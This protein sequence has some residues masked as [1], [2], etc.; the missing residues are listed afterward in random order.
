[1]LGAL[2][3]WYS[4]LEPTPKKIA[5]QPNIAEIDS[6][7][8]KATFKNS[9][10]EISMLTQQSKISENTS[11]STDQ[12]STVTF[13][14][15][16]GAKF[17]MA[18]LTK[19][20]FETLNG[21]DSANLSITI[22]EGQIQLLSSDPNKR[23]FEVTKKGKALSL[24]ELQT[25][26]EK[27][28]PSLPETSQI[29]AVAEPTPPEKKPVVKTLEQKKLAHTENSLDQ[30]DIN[31]VMRNQTSFLHRCYINYMLRSQRLD[32]SG[33]VVLSFVIQPTGKVINT[34]IISSPIQ[35]DQLDRCL[36]D[37]ISRASF[38]EFSSQAIL[39]QAYPIH[40]D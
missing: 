1:M 13:H 30:E 4:Q 32:L 40:L 24:E 27:E 11:L 26:I 19:I 34:K 28:K 10:D 39:V 16:S 25:H 22:L 17:E 38:K 31:K 29:Q 6:V 23:S 33:Q 2:V 8:G 12:D 35:D 15:L 18:P 3:F 7:V 14:L 21:H 5:S 9:Q 36:T 20:V 37:V